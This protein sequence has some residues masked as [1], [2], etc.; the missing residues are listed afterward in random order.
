MTTLHVPIDSIV[1][2][3]EHSFDFKILIEQPSH[4]RLRRMRMTIKEKVEAGIKEAMKAKDQERLSAV[5]MIKA[6]LLLKEKE[7][8]QPLDDAAADQA[9]QKMYKKYNK[10][11]EE[12]E[13]LGKPAE[14]KQ[15][16]RDMQVIKSYLSAPLMD[17]E[18]IERELQ[19]L[20]EEMHAGQQDFGK[21]MKAF[22][23]AHANAD[24][25]VVSTHLKNI[26]AKK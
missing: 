25:K 15:Y 17:E 23:S 9:L 19:Q 24:G 10:V 7:T 6:E 2:A 1:S 16:E 4:Y 21:V 3:P 5:R 26:L 22:M 12:Y 14:A 13:S 20:V 11:K 8:G 18:Q